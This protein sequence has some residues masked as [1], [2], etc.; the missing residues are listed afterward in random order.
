MD[1][2]RTQFA[3]RHQ[4]VREVRHS[5]SSVE[6]FTY[7]FLTVQRFVAQTTCNEHM[8]VFVSVVVNQAVLRVDNQSFFN[9]WELKSLAHGSEAM[10]LLGQYCVAR[11]FRH[12]LK[13]DAVEFDEHTFEL[14]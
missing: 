9:H 6:T 13:K 5:Y 1:F 8:A 2:V 14:V 4:I 10:G 3:G 11:A 7:N 12:D